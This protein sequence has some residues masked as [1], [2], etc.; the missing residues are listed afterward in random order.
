MAHEFSGSRDAVNI[1]ATA[2]FTQKLHSRPRVSSHPISLDCTIHPDAAM[3]PIRGWA[4]I[5]RA[6]R[7]RTSTCLAQCR[8]QWLSHGQRRTF[9]RSTTRLI[10]KSS[11]DPFL[12][13]NLDKAILDSG[14]ELRPGRSFP[15]EHHE[16]VQ[17]PQA[18]QRSK[19]GS[20][21]DRLRK[22]KKTS[23]DDASANSH[24]KYILGNPRNKPM[25][26]RFAPSPTGD[27]HL[28][29]LKTALINQIVAKST[30]GG[31]F[32][33]RIEDTDQVRLYPF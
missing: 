6:S 13:N 26:T 15:P 25:R 22:P 33:L 1:L 29:S 28:G 7:L 27:M 5:S 2:T 21:K 12:E 32:I 8:L 9:T 10:S 3:A 31:A 23:K 30:D 20:L 14:Q 11:S 24:V 4:S 18:G 16:R 17:K 19:A